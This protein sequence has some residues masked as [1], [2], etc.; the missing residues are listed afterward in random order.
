MSATETGVAMATRQG[1]DL[2]LTPKQFQ[3]H[4]L[5]ISPQDIEVCYGGARGGGKSHLG[6]WETVIM[7]NDLCCVFDLK[8]QRYPPIVGFMG[9]KR[10]S[11]FRKTT[12]E[13]F[14]RLI[15]ANL[16][17]I[18]EQEGTINF[19]D[20][21][22]VLVGGL[23]DQ[24]TISKFKSMEIAFSFID[25]AEETTIQDVSDLRA[26]HR[27]VINKKR[28]VYRKLYTANPAE[29]W[30]KQEFIPPW[31]P[32]PEDNY[33]FVPALPTDNPHLPS[34]YL[35]VL[36]KA[37]RHDDALLRAMLYGDWNVLAGFK[38][39]V[40]LNDIV[41][42]YE[43][44]NSRTYPYTLRVLSIDPARFGDDKF[45]IY[46]WENWR[47]IEKHVF[48]Q[49]DS[50]KAYGVIVDLEAAMG[51]KCLLVIDADGLGGPIFDRLAR[52][53]KDRVIGINNGVPADNSDMFFNKRSE[54]AWQ[55]REF[56]LD[57]QIIWPE[58]DTDLHREAC[59][60]EYD[61]DKSTNKIR[62]MSKEEMKDPKKLGC[63][64]DHFDAFSYG[65]EGFRW[66][67]TAE[68]KEKFG[69]ASWEPNRPEW[70]IKRQ[71]VLESQANDPLIMQNE[72][73]DFDIED[74][75]SGPGMLEF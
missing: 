47:V 12:L 6:C 34:G 9:R 69:R 16:Y 13:T 15:P 11:D 74:N 57:T 75:I 46:C 17:S 41:R 20:R 39:I 61:Y 43:R 63:S 70:A 54:L 29:C 66:L 73:I 71:R 33:H 55:V 35:D 14:K 25:Q 53:F 19:Q 18:N 22:K 49:I 10:A 24:K 59:M 23:D 40:K 44:N 65:I 67:L 30:L 38:K 50:D 26:A 7:A 56:T 52:R 5:L 4:Q 60:I 3:A 27:L 42:C 51:G 28:P 58:N 45:V 68:G 37:Y 48:G 62:I 72:E 1:H 64:C 8:P 31:G 2:A 32:Q 36:K 21:C